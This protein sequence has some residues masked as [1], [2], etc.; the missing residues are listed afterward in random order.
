[1]ARL[2]DTVIHEVAHYIVDCLYGFQRV[3]PHGPEW[4]S[5]MVDLGGI[6]RYIIGISAMIRYI[7][8]HLRTSS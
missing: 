6:Y 4:K 8:D 5:I 7:G 1:M 3:K 2:S